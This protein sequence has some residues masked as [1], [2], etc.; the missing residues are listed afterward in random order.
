MIHALKI[1]PEYFKAVANLNKL[2][3]VRKAD[4]PFRVGDYLALN[5]IDDCGVYTGACI[6]A[7]ISY[8]L[9]YPAYLQEGYVVLGLTSNGVIINTKRYTDTDEEE[10]ET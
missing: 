6:L 8:I 3:E 9:D 5:E 1:K 10:N 2:F 4:R 7:K